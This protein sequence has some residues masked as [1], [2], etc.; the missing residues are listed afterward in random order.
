MRILVAD[1]DVE[2]REPLVK[3]LVQWGHTVKE[4]LSESDILDTCR[5]KCPDI[6]FINKILSGVMAPD[7]IRR[8]R[9]LGGSALWVPVIMMGTTLNDAE[10]LAA[11]DAG[12][13][14]FLVKPPKEILLLTKIRAAERHLNLKDEVYQVAHNLV[15][16]NRAL[17]NV[18][19]QD[20]LT[21]VGNSNSFEDALEREWFLAKKTHTPLTL[22]I[23]NL[24]YFYTYNQTY[25]AIQG[26][27]AI[28]QVAEIWKRALSSE[29][30][31]ATSSETSSE[32]IFIARLSGETFAILLPRTSN[33]VG[34]K[35]AEHLRE[36][37]LAR[38]IP[39]S[40]SGA[41]EYLTA[42][43]GVSTAG[44]LQYTNP[45]DLQEAADYALF[46]AKHH[47]RNRCHVE[48]IEGIDSLGGRSGNSL[49]YPH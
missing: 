36:A 19:T 2:Q 44:P 14:D 13:D 11:I 35:I 30:S 32:N 8:L 16:A 47:G 9:Q 25:G 24:D 42:S 23:S 26:D 20:V 15:V 38:K 48:D 40:G 1:Q 7:L 33:E 5:T 6:I 49:S 29:T 39:H 41:S 46:Q 17:E 10:M 43:F 18:A 31:S 45:F 4:T 37:L 34:V 21:G 22:I 3:R 28:R 12:V 27:N